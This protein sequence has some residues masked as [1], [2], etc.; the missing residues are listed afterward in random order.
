MTFKKMRGC[1][2]S[3]DKQ[4]YIYFLCKNYK[5][6]PEAVRK[7]IKSIAEEVGGEYSAA[8]FDVLVSG[9]S[10]RQVAIEQYVSEMTLYNLRIAF[11]EKFDK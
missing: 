10:I 6:Q 11:Y 7:K 8:L 9:K 3:Y 2:L 4:G 1:S 5:S